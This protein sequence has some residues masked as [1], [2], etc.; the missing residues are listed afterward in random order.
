MEALPVLP[1]L[2]PQFRTSTLSYDNIPNFDFRLRM[3]EYILLTFNA[4]PHDYDN[5][6]EQLAH[7]KF[8]ANIPD[9]T[10]EQ[11]VK[12]KKYYSQLCM[13]QKRF[14]MGAGEAMETP[15]AWHDGLIDMRSAQSEVTICDIEFEK[16]SVLFNIEHQIGILSSATSHTG[17]R[18]AQHI[19]KFRL[20]LS[21]RGFGC[22]CYI[23]L[24]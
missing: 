9:P 24:L 17:V 1:L 7:M 12:L 18:T 13:M 23:V 21:I 4:D 14:P 22:Q 2:A 19:P 16:A 5:A 11:I 15:F 8:E 6:F 3:K 20:F 10:P